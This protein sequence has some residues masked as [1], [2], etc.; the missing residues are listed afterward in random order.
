MLD[1]LLKRDTA[2]IADDELFANAGFSENTCRKNG[3][4]VVNENHATSQNYIF[5]ETYVT[6]SPSLQNQHLYI[7]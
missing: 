5:L 4:A 1:T 7:N 3:A 2:A 6:T